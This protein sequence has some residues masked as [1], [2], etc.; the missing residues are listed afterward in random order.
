MF[1]NTRVMT[2]SGTAIVLAVGEYTAWGKL[3]LSL[4]TGMVADDEEEDVPG[5][6]VIFVNYDRFKESFS[7]IAFFVQ[8]TRKDGRLL[9]VGD[10]FQSTMKLKKKKRHY[11]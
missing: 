1:S 7:H 10:S 6:V 3:R 4:R 2:G 5:I 11:K 9:V 8:L